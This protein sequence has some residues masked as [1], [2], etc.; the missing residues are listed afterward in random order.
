MFKYF[1]KS[2]LFK[3]FSK[4]IVDGIDATY[5]FSIQ[6]PNFLLFWT[7]TVF[8][9]DHEFP[10]FQQIKQQTDS[11]YSYYV[12]HAPVETSQHCFYLLKIL[13]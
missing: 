3:Y 4:Y 12:L 1:K 6:V 10:K 13:L 8:A 5:W 11:I 7:D 9:Q 2:Y